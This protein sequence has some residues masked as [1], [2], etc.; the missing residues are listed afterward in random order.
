MIATRQILS[1]A[2][3]K[4]D[5][6][7]HELKFIGSQKFLGTLK[8]LF[9]NCPAW[10]DV[11]CTLNQLHNSSS[12]DSKP[13]DILYKNGP[14]FV[15]FG[16]WIRTPNFEN[17]GWSTW[18]ALESSQNEI[19]SWFDVRWKALTLYFATHRK[20]MTNFD[21]RPLSGQNSSGSD[22]RPI[23]A[24]KHPKVAGNVRICCRRPEHILK[25]L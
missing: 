19:W 7:D 8:I 5:C 4:I 25:S 10:L 12:L 21:F 15:Y 24:G 18:N 1:V 2:R 17:L 13:S 3:Q 11:F 23:M 16:T 22:L 9:L 6:G 20:S 14:I